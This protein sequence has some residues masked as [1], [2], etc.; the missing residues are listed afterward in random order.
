MG[1][2]ATPL[3]H[4]VG[5]AAARLGRRPPARRRA[6][7]AIQA[8]LALLVF[9]FLVLAVVTQW[10][11]LKQHDV[12]F[13]AGWLVPAFAVLMGYYVLMA[14]GWDF[15]LRFL[16]GRIAPAR[17]QL[18]WGQSLLA[19]YVPGNVLYVVGRVVLA[20]REGVSRRVTLASMIYEAGLAFV[21][22]A[23]LGAYFFIHHPDLSGQ[24]L[25]FAALAVLPIGVL[26]L[27]PR[28]FGPISTAV[29][30]RFGRQPLPVVMPL[31]GVLAML[32]YYAGTWLVMGVGLFFVARSVHA[33]DVGALP[34]VVSAEAL[35]Y[36]AAVM[37]LV[38]PGG[39]GIRDGAFAWA[40]KVAFDGSFA[41]AAAVAIAAR[42]VLTVVEVAYVVMVGLIA[43]RRRLL[44][45]APEPGG[46]PRSGETP[47]PGEPPESGRALRP[48]ARAGR[49]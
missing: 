12:R 26:A 10:S 27:H 16:G 15:V 49:G 18:I 48:T 31:R 21:A 2:R 6:R 47:E 36:C 28:V 32:V 45:P 4:R 42:L 25:R 44:P 43:S 17:G 40:L 38:F 24:P 13:E 29:L 39:L 33:I 46:T 5:D 1:E 37:T 9:G 7:I 20:E 11:E 35:G 3:L 41:V 23:S 34:T 30:R 22:G 8:G 19:R 14:Q